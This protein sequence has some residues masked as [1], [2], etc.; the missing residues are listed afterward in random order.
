MVASMTPGARVSLLWVHGVLPWAVDALLSALC[1]VSW[2]WQTGCQGENES[3]GVVDY[4]LP[5]LQNLWGLKRCTVFFDMEYPDSN[6]PT[7]YLFF[8]KA[9]SELHW[10]SQH[11]LQVS[12]LSQCRGI[13]LTPGYLI[14]LTSRG[15]SLLAPSP[16]I[17]CTLSFL[18]PSL[19]VLLLPLCNITKSRCV[20]VWRNLLLLGNKLQTALGLLLVGQGLCL[21]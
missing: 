6:V 11:L 10:G 12:P 9:D 8:L 15:V 4:L 19:W 1:T 2:V 17:G 5:S 7:G 21:Q 3:I 13:V 14:L 18:F 20:V 16:F